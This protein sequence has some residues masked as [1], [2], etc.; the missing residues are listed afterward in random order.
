[1]S[2]SSSSSGNQEHERHQED[3]DQQ[4]QYQM[5]W[6]ELGKQ[7]LNLKHAG[8][9]DD[10]IMGMRLQNLPLSR[11]RI[12]TSTTNSNGNTSG[13]GLFATMDCK[14][15]D[16]LTCYPGDIVLHETK[17]FQPTPNEDIGILNDDMLRDYLVRYCIGITEEYAIMGLPHYDDD[18]AYA[19]HF[20][21]DGVCQ[22]PTIETELESYMEESTLKANVQF[23]PLENLHLV[24]LATRD[25]QKGEELFVSYGPL[26]WMEH[27]PTWRGSSTS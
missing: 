11:T 24:G 23:L 21:N 20:I 22:P 18:M 8:V 19:G 26:Y 14:Q 2:L 15:G 16:F 1:M 9:P 10:V 5:T 3:Q 4:Q 7:L 12:D 25:I 13:R 17:G 27:T 6:E